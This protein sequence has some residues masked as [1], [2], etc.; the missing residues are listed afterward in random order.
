[1]TISTKVMPKPVRTIVQNARRRPIGSPLGKAQS[2][3]QDQTM[4]SAGSV[5]ARKAARLSGKY[6]CNCNDQRGSPVVV[7]V[8]LRTNSARVRGGQTP[9][10]AGSPPVPA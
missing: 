9:A 7:N 2:R 5:Q 6:A 8:E 1:M 3:A 10:A 4:P